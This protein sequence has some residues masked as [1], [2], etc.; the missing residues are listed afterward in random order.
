MTR[1][2]PIDRLVGGISTAAALL[3]L[4]YTRS[5]GA[6]VGLLVGSIIG[7]FWLGRQQICLSN[8]PPLRRIVTYV[9]ALLCI[10]YAGFARPKFLDI[11]P[12]RLDESKQSIQQTVRSLTTP[13]GDRDRIRVW[14]HT[15][16]MALDNLVLGVGLGNWSAIYPRYDQGDVLHI[17]S[18]P[19][20]P[21]NDYLWLFSELGILGLVSFL[22]CLARSVKTTFGCQNTWRL[23][24][25][26]SAAAI[27]THAFFSFPRE[28]AVLSLF[29]WFGIAT[30]QIQ[31]RQ[32]R[33]YPNRL[34]W[35][36]LL[37]VSFC[38]TAFGYRA[39]A[40]DGLYAK[41]FVA[42]EE[43]RVD[44]QEEASAASIE[45]G[46]IDHRVYLLLADAQEKSGKR[47]ESISTYAP[48]EFIQPKL[49][50]K[51]NNKGRIHNVLGRFYE[52]EVSLKEGRQSLPRGRPLIN[53]LAEAYRKQ[54]KVP[55][56]LGLY[57]ELPSL[58]VDEHQNLGLLYAESDS[59]DAALFHYEEVLKMSPERSPIVYSVAGLRLIKGEFSQAIE[60]YEAYLKSPNPNPI[61]VRRSMM[62]LRQAYTSLAFELLQARNPARAVSALERR[63]ELG[64][65]GATAYHALAQAYGGKGEFSLA[66][67]A[68]RE[69]LRLDP[70]LTI[71]NFTLANALYEKKDREAN[72]YYGAF[73]K[74]WRG[75]PR[76]VQV[77]RA[78]IGGKN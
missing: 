21:H 37:V 46:V 53:N 23:T 52:A 9:V 20:R 56:A 45:S 38:G 29:L 49:A 55:E 8:R 6:W 47:Q 40:S 63:I 28:Q 57:S 25:L 43:G 60:G 59:V 19:R 10:L 3:F 30:S 67:R 51:K 14:T 31:S 48:Y 13:D 12:S 22:W 70:D 74:E 35:L 32:G 18:A 50:A 4:L 36:F 24:G 1:S 77:A 15:S 75:D 73:L 64:E 7:F 41:G 34:I 69:A 2:Q 68:A 76:L 39:I 78:R 58:D 66:E 44:I 54:G 72:I 27:A 62:R 71:A 65:A 16:V 17:Q 26:C 33:L 61:L 5:R 11:N 42:Q